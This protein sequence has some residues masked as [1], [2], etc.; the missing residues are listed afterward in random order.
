MEGTRRILLREKLDGVDK[1]EDP[2]RVTGKEEPLPTVTDS[3]GEGG[4]GGCR[5][6]IKGG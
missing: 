4:S 2:T 5:M 3:V 6:K 1:Q